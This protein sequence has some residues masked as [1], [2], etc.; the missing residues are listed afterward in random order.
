MA[1]DPQLR[2]V[3]CGR[4]G[5]S[6]SFPEATEPAFRATVAGL[7]RGH[8]LIEALRLLREHIGIGLQDAK[9]VTQHIASSPGVCHRCGAVLMDGEPV[10]CPSCGSLNYDW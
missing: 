8:Q 2:V 7:V 9:A 5:S 3:T 4:C 1:A 6:W 10:V